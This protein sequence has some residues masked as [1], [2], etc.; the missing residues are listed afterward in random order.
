MEVIDRNFIKD[1]NCSNKKNAKNAQKVSFVYEGGDAWVFNACT[2]AK[3]GEFS[4]IDGYT[5]YFNFYA[6]KDT[7]M[8]DADREKEAEESFKRFCKYYETYEKLVKFAKK[9][10]VKVKAEMPK[11]W[12]LQ[13]LKYLGVDVPEE[14]K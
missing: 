3:K 4:K 11:E 6:M 2:E 12:I 14:L 5:L 1:C 8:S 9:N 13:E 10:G 7:F